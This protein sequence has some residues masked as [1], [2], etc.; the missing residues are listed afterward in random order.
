MCFD[1]ELISAVPSPSV[2]NVRSMSPK[3][4]FVKVILLENTFNAS[5]DT[6][7]IHCVFLS[8]YF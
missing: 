7:S 4:A 6:I 2:L 5:L 3:D 1:Q 8:V